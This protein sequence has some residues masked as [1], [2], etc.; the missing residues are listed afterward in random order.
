MNTK[1]KKELITKL[2]NRKN[3]YRKNELYWRNALTLIPKLKN[4]KLEA[5]K[6]KDVLGHEIYYVKI[7]S[8]NSV[9]LM[10]SGKS[11]F[12]KL[13]E[14]ENE[15]QNET[16]LQNTETKGDPQ[17]QIPGHRNGRTTK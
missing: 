7:T 5:I 16:P 1:F 12:D 13:K 2:A 9:H 17:T 15:E 6:H 14:M 3:I 11:T 4:M 10:K 8:K